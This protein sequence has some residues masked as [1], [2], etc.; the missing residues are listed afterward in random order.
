MPYFLKDST[1]GYPAISSI[2]RSPGIDAECK[3]LMTNT[4]D[5]ISNDNL[6]DQV[7]ENI[8]AQII[9]EEV[10]EDCV[11]WAIGLPNCEYLEPTLLKTH[12]SLE[13][14]LFDT[15]Y[16]ELFS[17]IC[18]VPDIEMMIENVVGY[19]SLPTFE[20]I[21]E[22]IM[23]SDALYD[24][25]FGISV[26]PAEP[27][28]INVPENS[29]FL[30]PKLTVGPSPFLE[31]G[32]AG[33]RGG[34]A[35][36]GGGAVG[37]GGGA[38]GSGGGAAGGGAGFERYKLWDK[39]YHANVYDWYKPNWSRNEVTAILRD[40]D[41]HA[42]IVYEVLD[43]ADSTPS[44]EEARPLAG[45]VPNPLRPPTVRVKPAKVKKNAPLPEIPSVVITYTKNRPLAKRV[46][47]G[48]T[49]FRQGQKLGTFQDDRFLDV[50]VDQATRI[51]IK[52]KDDVDDNAVKQKKSYGQRM[53][54]ALKQI[55]DVEK[56]SSEESLDEDDILCY[57]FGK[58]DSETTFVTTTTTTVMPSDPSTTNT[59]F[60]Q[61][62]QS[63]A[64][65]IPE[66]T[67]WELYQHGDL[68]RVAATSILTNA[69]I[70]NPD[71][72]DGLFLVRNSKTTPEDFILS[73]LYLHH[74]HNYLFKKRAFCFTLKTT[75]FE[76]DNIEDLIDHFSSVENEHLVTPLGAFVSRADFSVKQR[77]RT[78]I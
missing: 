63:Y 67:H 16:A 71:A 46:A 26:Y 27:L 19:V 39:N 11:E 50:V 74:V 55:G 21:F 31:K 60:V 6:V 28:Y 52:R 62:K 23:D 17:V 69:A 14:S 75:T 54:P 64:Q 70:L 18:D 2:N 5:G 34:A 42:F 1:P 7:L 20:R 78:V 10:Y 38:A 35:G 57:G 51:I 53:F 37:S 59:Y 8:V 44:T 56:L 43:G 40:S 47:K 61:N 13:N 36:S 68:D 25:L 32:G 12:L 49:V 66:L 58:V 48:A 77:V 29:S 72:A 41:L 15:I 76:Y 24:N 3:H 73:V 45:R 65:S 9:I 30:Y 22:D 33:S 4:F